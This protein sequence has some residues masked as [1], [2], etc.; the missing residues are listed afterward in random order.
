MGEG[1]GVGL[2][3]IGEG[4]TLPPKKLHQIQS[5]SQPTIQHQ[6]QCTLERTSERLAM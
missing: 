5:T 2:G 1:D 6:R 4:E 3:R